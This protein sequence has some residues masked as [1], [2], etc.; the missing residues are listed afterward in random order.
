MQTL[1]SGYKLFEVHTPDHGSSWTVITSSM[2]TERYSQHKYSFLTL[3]D[4]VL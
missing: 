3:W 4:M 1:F 2:H